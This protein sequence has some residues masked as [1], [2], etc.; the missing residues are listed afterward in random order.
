MFHNGVLFHHASDEEK[1]KSCTIE[2]AFVSNE[3]V[4]DKNVFEGEKLIKLWSAL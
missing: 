3:V 1:K 2:I 4:Q